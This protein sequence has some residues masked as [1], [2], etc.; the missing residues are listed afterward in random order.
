MSFQDNYTRYYND[1]ETALKQYCDEL[2]TQP[3]VLKESMTYSLLLGGKRI[4]PVLMLAVNEMLGG[5][6]GDIMPY[7]I[8]L[9]MIHTYTLIHDDLPGMDND[10]YRRGNLSNHKKF[11]EGNAI[12]AG[13]ALLNTAFEIVLKE[14]LKGYNQVEAAR[15]LAHCAGINGTIAGQSADLYFSEKEDYSQEDL[16]FIYT[17]KTGKLISAAILAASILSEGKYMLELEQ[18]SSVLGDLFQLTDDILDSESTFE[19]LG[20]SIGKDAKQNKLTAVKFYG[21]SEC[22]VRADLLAAQCNQILEG[23]PKDTAFLHELVDFVK[24]RRK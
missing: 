10:D 6:R 24:N 7:A 12:L 21:L 15:Y 8:A 22:K 20:K 5:K 2:H 17:N 16:E 13:D 11:G 23:I 3:T 1:F 4:R 18:F 19:E 9:E 14:C